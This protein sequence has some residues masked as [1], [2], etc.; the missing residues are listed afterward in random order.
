MPRLI[1]IG[2]AAGRHVLQALA[3]DRLRQHRRRRRAVTR[4]VARLRRDFLHHLRAHVLDR[5]AQLDLLR[6]R[7]TVL[8]HR[9][10][11]ELPVDHHVAALRAQRHLH[12]LRQL[13]HAALQRGACIRIKMEFLGSH[14]CLPPSCQGCVVSS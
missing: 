1:A 8:R 3:E 7:D 2:F 12:C 13:V 14:G 11:A 5:V 6:H 10:R 9:R 4:Q